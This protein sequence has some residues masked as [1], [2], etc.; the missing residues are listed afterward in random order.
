MPS[1]E[2]I[3][4]IFLAIVNI[5]TT[6]VTWIFVVF[7][8]Y[9]FELIRTRLHKSNATDMNTSC[10]S[11]A[12]NLKCH[13]FEVLITVTIMLLLELLWKICTSQLI[14]NSWIRIRNMFFRIPIIHEYRLHNAWFQRHNHKKSLVT[15]CKPTS[16]S[17]LS[18]FSW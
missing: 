4:L 13:V 11:C 10:C 6:I 1:S 9:G 7:H 3:M 17:P 5:V 16:F 15:A 18:S 14:H 8:D 2:S 12:S